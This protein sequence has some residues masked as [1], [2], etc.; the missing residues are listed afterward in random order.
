MPPSR[1][2]AEYLALSKGLSAGALLAHVWIDWGT[3]NDE[4]YLLVGADLLR[5]YGEEAL[6]ALLK[7]RDRTEME[8]FMIT[9]AGL[10]GV[11]KSEREAALRTFLDHQKPNVASA[12]FE[13]LQYLYQQPTNVL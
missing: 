7:Y 9:I 4:E 5:E 3:K 12:A 8:Y 10:K 13:A 11:V 6:M 2:Y 1:I